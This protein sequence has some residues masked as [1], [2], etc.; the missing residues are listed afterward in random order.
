MY[1][2]CINSAFRLSERFYITMPRVL[3][4]A[5]QPSAQHVSKGPSLIDPARDPTRTDARGVEMVRRS[6]RGVFFLA[7]KSPRLTQLLCSS[8]LSSSYTPDDAEGGSEESEDS[9]I[10]P[11]V[12]SHGG[13]K[14]HRSRNEASWTATQ[15]Q[16]RLH[17]WG[18]TDL[19]PGLKVTHMWHA[20]P[21][22]RLLLR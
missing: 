2:A 3:R 21:D 13:C 22:T 11:T 7:I 6:V 20:C 12:Q 14:H 9:K 1:L 4:L 19:W 10:L 16:I 17:R 5:P 18:N 15:L 8:T